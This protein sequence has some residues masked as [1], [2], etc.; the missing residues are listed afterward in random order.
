MVFLRVTS[1]KSPPSDQP[2]KISLRMTSTMLTL[3]WTGLMVK[4]LPKLKAALVGT[5]QHSS[6]EI[7]KPVSQ[8]AIKLALHDTS[9]NV[10]VVSVGQKTSGY[11]AGSLDFTDELL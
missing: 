4:T 3:G 11:K 2:S 8:L 7:F 5:F 6:A 9:A 1:P 10:A